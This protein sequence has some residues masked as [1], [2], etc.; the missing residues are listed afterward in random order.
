MKEPLISCLMVTKDRATL[1]RR[2]VRCFADQTWQN[3]E[4]VIVDDGSEDYTPVLAPFLQTFRIRYLRVEPEQGRYLGGLR[5]LSLEVAEGDFCA[6]WDDDEWYHPAR[7]QRQMR[8]ILS[9]RLDAV[10]LKWTLMHM[11]TPQLAAHPYRADAGDGTPG[12]ILH[13]RTTIRYP[14]MRRSEDARFLQTLSKAMRVGLLEEPHS[15]LFIR[16]YHGANTWEAKHFERRLRRTPR[17]LLQFTRAKFL[18]GDIFTHPAF[19][20]N[21]AERSAI[22][23]YFDHSRQLGVLE[24]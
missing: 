5:N 16:C 14:N 23:Q 24:N 4:L 12:T 21:A 19:R 22:D 18:R 20:L 6:Q 13:R 1:A 2:A 9:R 10:V 8:E 17:Q 7:L 15:H 11:D 3:K